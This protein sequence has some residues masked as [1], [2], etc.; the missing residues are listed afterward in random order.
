[1]LVF[2]INSQ[3]L[4]TLAL[5]VLLN[6]AAKL[7]KELSLSCFCH[8][9]AFKTWAFNL[10]KLAFSGKKFVDFGF[11]VFL[12]LIN[13]ESHKGN[14]YF[15]NWY[16]SVTSKT[17]MENYFNFHKNIWNALHGIMQFSEVPFYTFSYN[18]Y[19]SIIYVYKYI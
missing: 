10:R 8:S 7:T 15:F 12:L 3:L 2:V 18:A 19:L 9:F 17:K 1:M 16:F 11:C 14:Y 13:S 6:Y 5:P 4:I